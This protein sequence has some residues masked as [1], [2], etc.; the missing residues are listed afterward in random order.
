MYVS[1]GKIWKYVMNNRKTGLF[2]LFLL[3]SSIFVQVFPVNADYSEQISDSENKAIAL[4]EKMSPEEK[5]GQ[6]FLV[7]FQGAELNSESSIYD[8]IS[9]HHVGGV[10]LN[11]RND[12]FS[13]V[14]TIASTQNIIKNLQ[15]AEWDDSQNLFSNKSSTLFDQNN[16][17]PLFITI[18][19]DGDSYPNDQILNGI[20]PLPN[21]MAIGATW[22]RD[23]ADR[24]GKVMGQELN[25]IGFNFYLGP[26]LDVL[27]L[28]YVE[29]GDD[30][31]T[32]TF[33]GDPYWVG[34]M[35]Q[36]FISGIHE[37]SNNQMAVVAKH[38]PGRGSSDR[39]PEEEVATVRK[40]LEQLKQIE[41]APFFAVTGNSSDELS[42]VDGLLVSHIRYQGFQGNIRATTRPVSFDQ[43]AQEQLMSLPEFSSWRDKGGI[44]VS[45]N[46]GS[47]AVRKFFDPTGEAY[48]PRQIARN[49][50]LSG[51]DLLLLDLY[52]DTHDLDPYATTLRILEYFTQKYREDAAFA[53]RVDN[54]VKRILWLKFDLYPEFSITK[55]LPVESNLEIVGSNENASFE[56]ANQ[57]AVLMSPDPQELSVIMPRPP[58][59]NER[60]VFV[61][62]RI[63]T[64]QCST[65]PSQDLMAVDS[66]QKAVMRLYGPGAG[67]QVLPT[68][69]S[70]FSYT[71]VYRYLNDPSSYPTIDSELRNASW[72]IFSFIKPDPKNPESLAL[73]LFLSE[74]TD[75]LRDKKIIAFGFN[76]PY[77]LDAT[78]ISK[79]TAYYILFSKTPSFIDM[80]ARLLFQESSPEG[81]LPVSVPGIG[82]DLITAM[83]PEPTQV[84][85]LFF[86]SPSNLIPTA[87][88]LQPDLTALPIYELSNTIEVRT[89]VIHDYN[90]NPVP[91]GTVVR[92]VVSY[93]KDINSS[94]QIESNTL[95]GI[96]TAAIRIQNTGIVEIRASSDPAVVSDVLQM[97]VP[98]PLGAEATIVVLNTPQPTETPSPTISPTIELLTETPENNTDNQKSFPNAMNWFSMVLTVSIISGS[99]FLFIRD[100]LPL[101]WVVRWILFGFIGGIISYIIVLFQINSKKE[102]V[103]DFRSADILALSVL[104]IL[105]GWFVTWIWY[106]RN[107]VNPSK[108]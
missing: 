70:S 100:K 25:A 18:S 48:D 21:E 10:I 9:N 40:S 32:R 68:R 105:F 3:L 95:D 19:Q 83:S 24:I 37:G 92:F 66:L 77:Y 64:S 96:A 27:D 86:N 78:D 55:V 98:A 56:V 62:E 14:D 35:G 65:C 75:L 63:S 81:T 41:L 108:R 13:N 20:T 46:L 82:Y 42:T 89:G 15:Q 12:N 50:F 61:T 79:L 39:L 73:K 26:S 91:D 38:F 16:Y 88:P 17:V 34:E 47:N 29:G 84:I 69:M 71:D 87:D 59:S 74:R 22:N 101:R 93:Q 52:V 103:A 30:L 1:V 80:A 90:N 99:F 28:P 60:I 23:Y 51:N 31:G 45:D 7:S 36:A 53:Q 94:Q 11:S 33:G 2:L 72:I 8:L 97:E 57:S 54:S 76:A 67:E 43:A 44:I 104:G 5:I 6:L 106:N 4:L 85:P 102:I 49:A 58:Q 107:S